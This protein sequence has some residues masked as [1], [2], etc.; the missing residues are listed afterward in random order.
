M[1]ARVASFWLSFSMSSV[2]SSGDDI[3]QLAPACVSCCGVA[4][5]V[6]VPM[7]KTLSS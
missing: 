1:S 5:P 2:R 4:K 3:R 7:A 6:D